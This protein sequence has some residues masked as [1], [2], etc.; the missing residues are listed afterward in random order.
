MSKNHILFL[1]LVVRAQTMQV[2][3][4]GQGSSSSNRQ[5]M[6]VGGAAQGLRGKGEAS[7]NRCGRGR[8]G[9]SLS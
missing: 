3:L 2:I 7:C 9:R 6:T 8:N 5:I 1:G 4:F